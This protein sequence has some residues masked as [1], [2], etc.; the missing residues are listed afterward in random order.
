[1]ARRKWTYKS[2]K[3]FIEVE[4][5]SGCKLLSTEYVNNKTKLYI[6]CHCG[7]RFYKNFKDFIRSTKKQCNICSGVSKLPYEQIKTFINSHSNCKLLTLKENYINTHQE[8]DILCKCGNKF[9][10]SYKRFKGQNKRQC[11]ECGKKIRIK[12]TI[13]NFKKY[14][15][16]S[17]VTKPKS[18]EDFTKDVYK[19]HGNNYTILGKYTNSKNKILVKHNKCGYEW[20]VT[21]NNFI[22]KGSRCPICYGNNIKKDTKEFKEIVKNLVGD[23]YEVLGEYVNANINILMKHNICGHIWEMNPANFIYSGAR[24]PLCVISKGEDKVKEY[25]EE[26]NIKYDI[27]HTFKDCKNINTLPFDFYLTEQGLLIEYDGE[28]HYRPVNFGGCSD[29]EALLIHNRT[30]KH[31]KIKNQYC[32]K[33]KIPLLRIPYWDF[34][35]IEDILDE[36]LSNKDSV[37]FIA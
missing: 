6:Q 9:K 18:H 23:E 36:A 4:S 7:N 37:Y 22:H 2:V 28:Q 29:D 13:L 33:N 19:V 20:E 17:P 26:Y 30:K 5:N 14:A 3:H 8:L 15:H 32:L 34:D 12:K 10:T 25:L 27:Q 24:C 11:N 31:D 16:L 21:P 1:M 35:N